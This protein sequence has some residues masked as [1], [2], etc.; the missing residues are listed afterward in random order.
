MK[1]ITYEWLTFFFQNFFSSYRKL[2][3]NRYVPQKFSIS[4]DVMELSVSM[5]R[6]F[7]VC[8]LLV[9]CLLS[10]QYHLNNNSNNNKRFVKAFQSLWSLCLGYWMNV[11]L[12]TEFNIQLGQDIKHLCGVCCKPATYLASSE[13]SSIGSIIILFIFTDEETEL[14]RW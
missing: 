9:K 1:W 7:F 11:S 8:F 3:I 4:F 6:I 12:W 2:W 5:D 10:F 14:Q 13:L